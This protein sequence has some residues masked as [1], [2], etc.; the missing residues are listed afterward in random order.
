[1]PAFEEAK[2]LKAFLS[3]EYNKA[4]NKHDAK[5]RR[6]TETKEFLAEWRKEAKKRKKLAAEGKMDAGEYIEWLKSC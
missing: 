3:E 6:G 5:V 2:D 1:M 4:S